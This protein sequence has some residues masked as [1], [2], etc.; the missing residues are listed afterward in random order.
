MQVSLLLVSCTNLL[1]DHEHNWD[2]FI[3]VVLFGIWTSVQESSKFT[4]FYLMTG[5][6]ATFPLEAVKSTSITDINQLGDLQEIID[7]LSRVW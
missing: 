2:E 5:I 1:N 3:N 4:P 6:E 7:Y